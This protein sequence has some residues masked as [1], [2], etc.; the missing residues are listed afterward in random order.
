[1]NIAAQNTKLA[2]NK[3]KI[4]AECPTAQYVKTSQVLKSDGLVLGGRGEETTTQHFFKSLENSL[5]FLTL[6]ADAIIQHNK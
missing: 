1:M 3:F 2:I 5:L 4:H 6:Q